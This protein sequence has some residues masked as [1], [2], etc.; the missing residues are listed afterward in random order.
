[1]DTNVPCPIHFTEDELRAH[2][3]DSDGWNEVQDFWDS[4]DGLVARDGWTS[5]ET[6]DEAVAMFANLR[7]TGMEVME[8]EEKER[9]EEQ[10]RWADEIAE[11]S[12]KK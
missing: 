2:A 9:F 10:T 5:H 6:Y 4:V 8:G 1:L 11:N 3:Q 12:A 7:K